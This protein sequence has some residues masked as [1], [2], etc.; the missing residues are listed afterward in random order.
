MQWE[1]GIYSGC[2]Q[3]WGPGAALRCITQDPEDP[4]VLGQRVEGS[5][6]ATRAVHGVSAMAKVA[7]HS[8]GGHGSTGI[9]S[10]DPGGKQRAVA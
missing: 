8:C 7:P 3:S 6:T 10:C 5:S 4:H 2:H 1:G 9:P